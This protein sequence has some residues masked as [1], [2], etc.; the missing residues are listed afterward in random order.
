MNNI[1]IFIY[2]ALSQIAYKFIESHSNLFGDEEYEEFEIYTNYIDSHI[3]FTNDEIQ[4]E[5][6]RFY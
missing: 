6:E 3:Y 4:S 1:N 2:E 5:F